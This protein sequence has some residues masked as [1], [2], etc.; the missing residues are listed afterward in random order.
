MVTPFAFDVTPSAAQKQSP[1]ADCRSE[2]LPAALGAAAI[3]V[4]A[5]ACGSSLRVPPSL[6]HGF[7]APGFEEVREEFARNF[8]ERGEAGAAVCA[9]WGGQ[10]VVDLWGGYRDVRTREPWN[11]DTLVM[12]MST[13][14]GLSAMT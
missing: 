10:K 12:V 3:S 8:A 9:Y 1:C 4:L 13:T 5:A 2:R 7:A 6:I 14:K 11:E